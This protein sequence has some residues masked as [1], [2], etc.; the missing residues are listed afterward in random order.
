MSVKLIP[1]GDVV[2]HELSRCSG[3]EI[4]SRSVE[5]AVQKASPLPVPKDPDAFN[6]M[7]DINFVFKPQ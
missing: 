7:R 3:D 2:T 1:T 6:L 4:F 5:A